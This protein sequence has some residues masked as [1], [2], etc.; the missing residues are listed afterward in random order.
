MAEIIGTE[1]NQYLQGTEDADRIVSFGAAQSGST[2][3][4]GLG[5]DDTLVLEDVVDIGVHVVEGD[6]GTDTIDLSRLNA[7]GVLD[8]AIDDNVQPLAGGFIFLTSV[9]NVIGTAFDDVL[10]GT[11]GQNVM[12]GGDGNDTIDGRGGVLDFDMASYAHASAGVTV[13]LAI[14]GV[15]QDT[16]GAGTDTLI[17]IS[18][19]FGSN[20][21]DFL[22]AGDGFALLSGGSGDDTLQGGS[23]GYDDLYGGSGNDVI[24]TGGNPNGGG[25]GEYDD[26]QG[27]AGDD[28]FYSEGGRESFFGNDPNDDGEGEVDTVTFEEIQEGVTASLLIVGTG[29]EVRAGHLVEFE[30]IENLVGTAFNDVLTGDDGDNEVSGGAGNDTIVGEGG[31]D[32]LHTGGNGGGEGDYAFGGEGDDRIYARSGFEVIHGGSAGEADT[33]LDSDWVD[34]YEVDVASSGPGLTVSLATDGAQEVRAGHTVVLFSIENLAG[35]AGNDL[36]TGDSGSNTL[37]GGEGDDT[38]AGGGGEDRLDGGI[39]SDTAVF[40][41]DRAEFTV[42]DIQGGRS[43]AEVADATNIDALFS[44]EKIKFDDGALVFDIFGDNVSFAYRIYAAAYG[45][46]PDEAGLRFWTSQLDQRGEGPPETDDKE[47]IAS[48]FLTADEYISKYGADP[49]NEEFI[50]KLYENVLHREADQAGYDFWLGVLSSGQGKDDMLI[51]FTDSQENLDN[52]AP[53]LDNGIWVL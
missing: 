30:S 4:D 23:G 36:L 9:E 35:S 2:T 8:L 45:R 26:I 50:N 48:Y 28:M 11:D 53:D 44:I 37:S 19:L 22:T 10:L 32:R 13:S 52:T 20:H 33:V 24:H 18:R 25:E 27:G 51:F 49:T 16:G 47:F 38:L 6:S 39:R 42:A 1:L 46:T 12:E 21:D 40:D 7:G 17:S 29:Q 43:V 15:A 41:G 3:L 31:S 34:F 5:G 14:E